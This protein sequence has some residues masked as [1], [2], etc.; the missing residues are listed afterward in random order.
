MSDPSGRVLS[1]HPRESCRAGAGLRA[2]AHLL[3]PRV[4]R[5]LLKP[6]VHPRFHP[7]AQNPLR[8][9]FESA[10]GDGE[11]KSTSRSSSYS[12]LR[13][14]MCT[15]MS[16]VEPSFLWIVPVP[17]IPLSPTDSSIYT[18]TNHPACVRSPTHTH[19]HTL[20]EHI[21]LNIARA[22]P[23]Q[24]HPL[25]KRLGAGSKKIKHLYISAQTPGLGG[26]YLDLLVP[27]ALGPVP[28]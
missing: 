21:L 16:M 28:V 17:I 15:G 18:H 23:R 2:S 27:L 24:K 20:V 5:R 22:K 10:G 13:S 19:T 12:C 1:A 6:R 7:R 4:R 9:C 26:V 11:E 14:P 25:K 3:R 8:P